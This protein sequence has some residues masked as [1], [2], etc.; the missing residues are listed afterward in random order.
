MIN[1]SEEEFQR[2]LELA[3]DPANSPMPPSHLVKAIQPLEEDKKL[4]EASRKR[5]PYSL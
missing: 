2:Q 5:D 4:K 3:L 1:F